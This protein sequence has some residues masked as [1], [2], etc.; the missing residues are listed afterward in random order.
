M[1]Y[2]LEFNAT[3]RMFDLDTQRHVTSRTY[4][5]F[6][7]EGRIRMMASLGYS[8]DSMLEAGQ[9]LQ[10]EL[11]HCS[12]SREQLPGNA[13]KVETHLE[14]D[15]ERQLWLQE[16]KQEDGVLACRIATVT[17]LLTA[18]TTLT[19]ATDESGVAHSEE[20]PMDY[21]GKLPTSFAERKNCDAVATPV[22]ALYS[23][24]T[25]FFSYPAA[26][27]WRMVEEGRWGFSYAIGLDQKRI[28]EMDT[29]T[30]FTS[31]TFG[32]YRQPLPGELL[33]VYTWVDRLEKIRCYLR[34][35][36]LDQQGN[37][38]MSN[39]EE[40]LIVSLSRRRPRRAGPE[41]IHMIEKYLENKPELA[42]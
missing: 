18:G 27:Y 31:G 8:L 16:V 30:F 32:I 26:A 5:A 7:W 34:S 14:L 1:S 17:R 41:Y 6:C 2:F 12:F 29:V 21:I 13:L 33:N 10:P 11:T 39:I 35:D 15:G 9:S 25:P 19:M 38:I 22:T 3:P 37:L 24:R 23:E 20:S 4:E 40:Q 36:V 42:G 28:L